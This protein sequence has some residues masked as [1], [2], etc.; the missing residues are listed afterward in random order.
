[1][2]RPGAERSR[3]LIIST[4]NLPVTVGS[5]RRNTP[6]CIGA[7]TALAWPRMTTRSPIAVLSP[8]HLCPSAAVRPW[9]RPL[10]KKEKPVTVAA[11]GFLSE[12]AILCYGLCVA[13][14]DQDSC[15]GTAVYF[16]VACMSVR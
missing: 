16:N 9:R 13:A 7:L 6:R 8:Q 14:F 3:R 10:P 12:P 1:M 5:S 11:A 4:T 2:T 15:A